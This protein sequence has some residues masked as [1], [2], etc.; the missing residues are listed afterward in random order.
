MRDVG[1]GAFELGGFAM[2]LW[3]KKKPP[4]NG[5]KGKHNTK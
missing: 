5:G 2:E 3:G 1:A 4:G